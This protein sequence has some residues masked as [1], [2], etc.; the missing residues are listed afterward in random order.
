MPI[1]VEVS[2]KIPSFTARVAGE[3][4]RKVDNSM[5]RF[6]KRIVVEAIPK[7]GDTLSLSTRTGAPF[8]CTVTRADWDEHKNMFVIACSH[9]RRSIP[10]EHDAL[11]ADPDWTSKLLG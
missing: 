9:A 4:D 5:V 10:S 6:A 11:L 2:L 1:E 8:E 3:P 7:A